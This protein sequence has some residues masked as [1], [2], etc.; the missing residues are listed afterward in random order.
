MPQGSLL[1]TPRP[2]AGTL[3]PPPP[4]PKPPPPSGAAAHRARGRAQRWPHAAP[5]SPPR[6]S[7]PPRA[8]AWR[9][10][11]LLRAF[12]S[13]AAGAAGKSRRRERV[14]SASG[15]AERRHLGRLDRGRRGRPVLDHRGGS[16]DRFGSIRLR[17]LHSG[18]GRQAPPSPPP[19]LPS[20]APP[21]PSGCRPPTKAPP[22]PAGFAARAR[23]SLMILSFFRLALIPWS[24]ASACSSSRPSDSSSSSIAVRTDVSIGA[25]LCLCS[26][27]KEAEKL[28]HQG[29]FRRKMEGENDT[30]GRPFCLRRNADKTRQRLAPQTTHPISLRDRRQ[31][32]HTRAVLVDHLDLPVGEVDRDGFSSVAHMAMSARPSSTVIPGFQCAS[33]SELQ[34]SADARTAL[35][36]RARAR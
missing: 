7:Y 26:L 5:R 20:A 11:R 3:V 14:T 15:A 6:A 13:V 25:C 17:L 19:R 28:K 23:S 21:Q 24:F 33:S 32:D 16:G 1:P 18:L 10:S 8:C 4:P 36:E 2:W 9:A 12:D 27:E 30:G 29:P 35:V 22:P 31:L 34:K